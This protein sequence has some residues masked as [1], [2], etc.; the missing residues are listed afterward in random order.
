MAPYS[1]QY[2][3]VKELSI[4]P[5]VGYKIITTRDR[6]HLN[7]QHQARGPGL[8]SKADKAVLQGPMASVGTTQGFNHDMAYLPRRAPTSRM[9][10]ALRAQRTV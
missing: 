6:K 5:K 4:D 10:D 1:I 8:H 7:F 2:R 3:R 9:E